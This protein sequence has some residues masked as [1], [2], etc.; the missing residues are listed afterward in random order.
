MKLMD[1]PGLSFGSTNKRNV[2]VYRGARVFEKLALAIA[3]KLAPCL[4]VRFMDRL[5]LVVSAP[6]APKIFVQLEA[7]L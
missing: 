1:R 3:L 5:R 4:I 6:P 7:R 2:I